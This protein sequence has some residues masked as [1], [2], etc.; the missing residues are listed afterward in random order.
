MLHDSC[1]VYSCT[2]STF[3]FLVEQW[4]DNLPPGFLVKEAFIDQPFEED[5]CRCHFTFVQESTSVTDPQLI[6]KYQWFVGERTP[7]NFT[8]IPDATGEVTDSFIMTSVFK[9][10]SANQLFFESNFKLMTH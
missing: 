7:S 4:K 5:T 10:L 9:F 2:D 3:S 6:Y 1:Y 8:S